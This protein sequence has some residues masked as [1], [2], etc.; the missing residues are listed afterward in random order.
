[1]AGDLLQVG[2][3]GL[4]RMS[5]DGKVLLANQGDPCCCS[6]C[7]RSVPR[8][9]VTLAGVNLI[10]GQC[11]IQDFAFEPDLWHH[12]APALNLTVD[13]DAY[14][15]TPADRGCLYAAAINNCGDHSIYTDSA[16]QNLLV[17]GGVGNPVPS[18]AQLALLIYPPFH[19][20]P[21][22]PSPSV[23]F[24]YSLWPGNSVDPTYSGGWDDPLEQTYVVFDRTLDLASVEV[25]CRTGFT[26]TNQRACSFGSVTYLPARTFLGCGGTA[27]L[28]P[29]LA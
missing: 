18:S 6:H 9:R 27:T 20:G 1:M 23:R 29:L 24:W 10:G 22:R 25:R 12:W 11:H 21:N 7:C 3:D 2:S 5:A 15:A 26:L 14:P 28:T 19:F 13:L 16:C 4:L 8:F 17:K